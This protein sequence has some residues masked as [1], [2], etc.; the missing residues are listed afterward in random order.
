VPLVVPARRP[1]PPRVSP[2]A[3]RPTTPAR[4]APNPNPARRV[5][6]LAWSPDGQRLAGASED[7]SRVVI[8]DAALGTGAVLRLGLE[9]VTLLR[10]SPCGGYLFAGARRAGAG[11]GAGRGCRGGWARLHGVSGGVRGAAARAPPSP[12]LASLPQT[13]RAAAG[14][15]G[16]FH[17][18]E[19]SQWRTAS[20]SAPAG[21]SVTAAAWAPGAR[22]LLLAFGGGAGGGSVVGLHF[23][24]EPPSLMEQVLPVTLPEV[25]SLDL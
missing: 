21:A 4:T 11:G 25:T 13:S 16:R 12:G 3:R 14:A 19:T 7:S 5:T 18:A 23:V 17:V 1:E 8:W 10:W 20:W 2:S 22:A 24:G 9:P 6:S 15:G